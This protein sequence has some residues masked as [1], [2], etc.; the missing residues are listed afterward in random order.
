MTSDRRIGPEGRDDELT[1]TLR[2]MYAA[3]GTEQYWR[4]LEQRILAR[5]AAESAPDGGWWLPLSR[6]ARSGAAAAA[7]ALLVAG[8]A[9]WRD[10]EVREQSA[11]Q[12][13]LLQGNPPLAQLGA[14]AG[15]APDGEAVLRYVLTP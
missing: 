6:W 14:A 13:M 11:V 2:G 5:V 4:D 7:A 12:A 9:L 3:P 8:V 1:R 15:T 10:R